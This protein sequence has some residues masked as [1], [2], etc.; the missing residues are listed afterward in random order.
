MRKI[1]CFWTLLCLP[2]AAQQKPL[3]LVEAVFAQYEDGPP[4]P[5]G[6]KYR[7]GETVFISFKVANYRVN[8]NNRIHLKYTV[9]ALDPA[10]LKLVPPQSDQVSEEL[11]PQDKNWMPKI[12]FDALVPPTAAP[13][14]YKIAATVTDE[15]GSG[16]KAAKE[17]PFQVDGSNMQPSDTI[18]VRDFAFYRTSEFTE[19]LQIAAFGPSD[20]VWA[21][22]LMTGYKFGPD[23]RVMVEYGVE[24]LNPEGK[25]V[26]SQPK[27]ADFN[28]ESFYPRRYVPGMASFRLTKVQPGEYTVRLTIRDLVGG[29]SNES[30]HPFRVE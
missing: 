27:A 15:M 13:G 10:G 14:E 19:P 7:A 8:Q 18:T 29:Q 12:R 23:N 26:F 11:S 22:F 30:T 2:V 5:S 1:I 9:E 24:L 21:R 3:E 16:Q 6:H 28:E 25:V 17:F 4:V 20:E